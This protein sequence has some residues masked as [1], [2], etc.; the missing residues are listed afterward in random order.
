MTPREALEHLSDFIRIFDCAGEGQIDNEKTHQ[1]FATLEKALGLAH[2]TCP[3]PYCKLKV[4][5]DA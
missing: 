1:A 3:S 4:D 5:E 2:V